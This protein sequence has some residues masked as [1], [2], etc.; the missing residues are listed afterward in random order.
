MLSSHLRLGLPVVSY[1][2]ASQPKPCKHLSPP[3]CVPHVP[4]TS[5]SLI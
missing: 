3:P 1:L 4:L 5:S 2:R